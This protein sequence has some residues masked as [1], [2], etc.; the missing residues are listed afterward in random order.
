MQKKWPHSI[1][2]QRFGN[3]AGTAL[4]APLNK[5]LKENCFGA[6]VSYVPQV[7]TAQ[8]GNDAGMI[9]AWVMVF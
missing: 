7:V 8:N 5:Y 1:R 4:T 9:G 6:S 2:S 3:F